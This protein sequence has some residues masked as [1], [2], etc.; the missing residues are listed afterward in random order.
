MSICDLSLI[1]VSVGEDTASPD[2]RKLRLVQNDCA[3]S[4]A[5]QNLIADI[6]SLDW[7]PE[8]ELRKPMFETVKGTRYVPLK[9]NTEK[10][11]R[12]HKRGDDSVETKMTKNIHIFMN[13]NFSYT[14]YCD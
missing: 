2:F 7:Y 9:E 10:K 3:T 8:D 14:V 1:S 6:E 4:T 11:R 13:T 12:L 5:F